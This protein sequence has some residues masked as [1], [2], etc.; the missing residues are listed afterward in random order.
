MTTIK[1]KTNI[2][3]G[4]CVKSVTPFLNE[5]DSIETWKVDTENPEKIL[6]VKLDGGSTEAVKEAVKKAGFEIVEIQ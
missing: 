3:C 2:N 1:F 5:V 6:E 4:N